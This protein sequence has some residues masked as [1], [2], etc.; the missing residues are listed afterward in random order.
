MPVRRWGTL[1]SEYRFYDC[2][3]WQGNNGVQT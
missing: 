1:L 3:G 2:R